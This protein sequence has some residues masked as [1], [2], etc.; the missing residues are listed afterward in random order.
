MYANWDFA[1][2]NAIGWG[3]AGVIWLFSFVFYLPLDVIKFS[4]RY[5]LRGDAWELITERRV[6]M[7]FIRWSLLWQLH[8]VMKFNRGA[9]TKT[10]QF[11]WI[12]LKLLFTTQPLIN[13]SSDAH[14]KLKRCIMKISLLGPIYVY[15]PKF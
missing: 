13:S 11:I 8:D 5:I 14:S 6:C 4:V 10:F 2:M 7:I 12:H 15:N 1:F 3:W 9:C